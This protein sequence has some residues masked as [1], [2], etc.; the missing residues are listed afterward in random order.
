MGNTNHWSDFNEVPQCWKELDGIRLELDQV[1][2]IYK[3]LAIKY[4][5]TTKDGR[6]VPSYAK[7]RGHFRQMYAKV[8]KGNRLIFLPKGAN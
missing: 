1:N 2:M 5:D 6:F 8:A 3:D 4:G 7:A